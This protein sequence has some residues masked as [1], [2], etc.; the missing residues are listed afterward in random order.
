[1][2]ELSWLLV[3]RL[4]F[5]V[6]PVMV[7]VLV[8]FKTFVRLILYDNQG[9]LGKFPPSCGSVKYVTISVTLVIVP[10]TI[11]TIPRTKRNM[12]LPIFNFP[13]MPW[14]SSQNTIV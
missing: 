6:D 3:F 9:H 7:L 1:M 13:D 2:R 11:P 8:F 14:K 12:F 5:K 4:L 10:A